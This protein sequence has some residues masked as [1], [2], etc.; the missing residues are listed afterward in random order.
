MTLL[1]VAGNFVIT[2]IKL[3]LE[4]IKTTKK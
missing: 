4:L 1:F 2:L 3:I